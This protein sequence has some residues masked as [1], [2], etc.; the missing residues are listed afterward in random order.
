[1]NNTI[2]KIRQWGRK[3][4]DSFFCKRWEDIEELGTINSWHVKTGELNSNSIVYSAGVGLDVSFEKELV[5]RFQLEVEL[6]DPSPVGIQ[7]MQLEENRLPQIHFN[8]VGFAGTAGT[9]KFSPEHS[10]V[11]AYA[12]ARKNDAVVEF[13]CYD[14]SSLMKE[15]KH[16]R[17]DLLKM[18]IEGFEYDVID[19]L[20]QNSIDVRQ[21]CV[22]FHHFMENIPRHKTK[23]A[24]SNLKKAGYLR[25]YKKR[26]DY[27]FL[28]RD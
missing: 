17:I 3:K 25:I 8:P 22:E 15:R 16:T 10:A 12:V 21:I 13:Q 5:S 1:M 7:T 4:Y 2:R 23:T 26:N 19:H 28:R 9:V 18:D 24:I 27:T 20:L 14:L 11:G 6:F